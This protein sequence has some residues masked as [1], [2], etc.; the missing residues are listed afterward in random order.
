MGCKTLPPVSRGKPGR[1]AEL[2]G[3]RAAGGCFRLGWITTAPNSEVGSERTPVCPKTGK[4]KTVLVLLK[5]VTAS[6]PPTP[7]HHCG[8]FLGKQLMAA[9]EL[10]SQ[11]L[12]FCSQNQQIDGKVLARPR[13]YPSKWAVTAAQQHPPFGLCTGSCSGVQGF[14]NALKKA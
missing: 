10:F 11:T 14:E 2:P 3:R 8:H 12:R 5:D 7:R 1:Q 13:A 4:T 9:S 6:N